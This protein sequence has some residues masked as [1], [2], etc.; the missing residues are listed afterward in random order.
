MDGRYALIAVIGELRQRQFYTDADRDRVA[1]QAVPV[2]ATRWWRVFGVDVRALL[3]RLSN[4][5]RPG[6]GSAPTGGVDPG[7]VLLID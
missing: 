5:S 1:Q 4:A 3:N 7:F 2:R 6:R